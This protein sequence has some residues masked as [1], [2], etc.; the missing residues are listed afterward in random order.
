MSGEQLRQA[1]QSSGAQPL[2]DHEVQDNPGLIRCPVKV[3]NGPTLPPF[4][5]GLLRQFAVSLKLIFTLFGVNLGLV[6]ASE[7]MDAATFVKVFWWVCRNNFSC[8]SFL[9]IL[10]LGTINS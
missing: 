3:H 1:R 4:L 5:G 6:H 8:A 7:Y 9:S 10:T 2:Y